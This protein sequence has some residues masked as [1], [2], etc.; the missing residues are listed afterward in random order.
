MQA[1][2]VAIVTG[3]AGLVG[4]EAVRQF[5]RLGLEVVGPTD[6]TI[7]QSIYFFDP[8]GHRLE[9]AVDT[10]TPS[11]RKELAAVSEPM[12]KEWSK[13]KKA[14]SHANWVHKK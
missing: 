13:T 12:L 1:G 9:L 10:T 6:H 7:C 4:A 3:S 8:N 14:P 11:M 2:S 5:A